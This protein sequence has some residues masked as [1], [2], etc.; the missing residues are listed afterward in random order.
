MNIGRFKALHESFCCAKVNFGYK[1][2][3]APQNFTP[4]GRG[5]ISLQ[6][7]KELI[8]L[9]SHCFHIGRILRVAI[10]S[11]NAVRS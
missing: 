9:Y 2:I 10:L 7:T 5:N 8:L 11:V 1:A 3:F 4:L 6:S